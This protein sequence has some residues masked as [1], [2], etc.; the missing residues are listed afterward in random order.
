MVA[1]YNGG[2]KKEISV[3]GVLDQNKNKKST[4]ILYKF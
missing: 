4:R 3:T 2:K 1:G